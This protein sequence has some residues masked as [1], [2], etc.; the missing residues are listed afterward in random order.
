MG[1][2]TSMSRVSRSPFCSRLRN[3]DLHQRHRYTEGVRY[4]WM[5]LCFCGVYVNGCLPGVFVGVGSGEL[6]ENLGLCRLLRLHTHRLA[7]PTATHK[8]N[9]ASGLTL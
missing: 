5:D 6:L 9:K 8:Q 7:T 4:D 1:T 3:V 2:S